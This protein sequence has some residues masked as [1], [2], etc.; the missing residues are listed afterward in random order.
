MDFPS[1]IK[2]DGGNNVHANQNGRAR[3]C[4]GYADGLGVRLLGDDARLRA[5][6]RHSHVVRL[7]PFA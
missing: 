3:G 1:T 5:G 4:T 7:K 6:R 2:G